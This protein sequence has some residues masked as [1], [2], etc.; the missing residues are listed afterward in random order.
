MVVVVVEPGGV[1][2]SRRCFD[3]L[4]KVVNFYC[5]YCRKTIRMKKAVI[6]W[7]GGKDCALALHDILVERRYE[8]VKLLSALSKSTRR[9]SMHGLREELISRQAESLGFDI[10]KIFLPDAPSNKEYEHTMSKHW[11]KLTEQGI[12]VSVFGDIFLED[13]REYRDKQ[14]A[15]M[16]IENVYPLWKADTSKLIRRFLDLGFRAVVVATEQKHF[17]PEI[18][19][20]EITPAFI[21]KLPGGVDPCGENGEFHTFVFDG[22][23]F[24]KPVEFTLGKIEGKTFGDENGFWF[25]DLLP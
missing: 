4:K 11:E 10:E 7:S 14:V 3:V 8:P 21:E 5:Y 25:L 17:G 12:S 19:G 18:L 15:A 20:Q 22:P 2:S 23:L 6:N 9:I 1:R 13:I 16:N 24:K